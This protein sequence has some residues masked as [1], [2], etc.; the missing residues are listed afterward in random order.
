MSLWTVACL[1]YNLLSA[2]APF[3]HN[4]CEAT[5]CQFPTTYPSGVL[6]GLPTLGSLSDISCTGIPVSCLHSSGTTEGPAHP[7]SPGELR[8][9]CHRKRIRTK[10]HKDGQGRRESCHR[11]PHTLQ[12]PRT[13]RSPSI[14]A[15][16]IKEAPNLSKVKRI[17]LSYK[18][19]PRI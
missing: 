1:L 12:T 15:G 8:G 14:D 3:H 16:P 13:E 4:A 5:F 10:P 19:Y 6:A 11:K 18:P 2:H 17:L 7:G 9:P